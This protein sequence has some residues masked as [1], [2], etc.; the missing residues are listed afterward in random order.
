MAYSN[1]TSSTLPQGLVQRQKALKK[2]N[3]TRAFRSN[4]K[5]DV[6]QRK[7][8]AYEYI[9]KPPEFIE[10]MKVIE[11]LLAIPKLGRVKA[12][13][14]LTICQISPSARLS[15]LSTRQRMELV[16]LLRRYG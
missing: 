9:L 13:R 16:S 2:A 8:T 7:V 10:T 4:L 3:T 11:L 14:L 6:K 12:Q 15:K 1:P 5:Q